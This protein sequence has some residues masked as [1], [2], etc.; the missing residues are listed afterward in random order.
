MKYCLPLFA[1]SITLAWA[2]PEVIYD[3]GYTR[4][5]W[6]YLESVTVK[7]AATE[8]VAP[9]AKGFDR[10]ALLPIQTLEMAPAKLSRQALTKEL[11]QQLSHLSRPLFLL[12]TDPFSQQWLRQYRSQLLAIG[13]VGML[14]D[15]TTITDLQRIEA[16]GK[17]L[18]IIPASASTLAQTLG[19]RH[20]PV[21]ISRQG[22]EQ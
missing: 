11:R 16:L 20:Y 6:P 9:S 3:S 8:V 21:L 15:V 13:A 5:L 22:I 10:S 12:G 4:P 17:G 1:L 2:A 14:V 19:L 7:Q 18:T